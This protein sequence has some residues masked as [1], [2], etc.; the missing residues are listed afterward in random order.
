VQAAHARDSEAVDLTTAASAAAGEAR[1]G[2]T[3]RITERG[4]LDTVVLQLA[5][6]ACVCVCVCVYCGA[7]AGHGCVCVCV[8]LIVCVWL[9]VCECDCV[10]D[11]VC[12]AI[13]VC[14]NANAGWG[15]VQE[16]CQLWRVRDTAVLQLLAAWHWATGCWA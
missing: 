9:H 5:A 12:V 11:C 14:R 15:C 7:A 16:V 13:C 6:G 2:G 10:V 3:Y 8:W 4:G 1:G